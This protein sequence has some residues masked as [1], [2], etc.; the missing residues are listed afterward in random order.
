[1]GLSLPLGSEFGYLQ[2]L[3]FDYCQ[4][5]QPVNFADHLSLVDPLVVALGSDLAPA[6]VALSLLALTLTLRS[7]LR[8]LLALSLLTLALLPLSLLTGLLSL[9]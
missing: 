9:T 1:M 5:R 6:V 8:T 7:I 4:T 2:N 3:H